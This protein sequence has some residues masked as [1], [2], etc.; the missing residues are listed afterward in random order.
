MD[1]LKKIFHTLFCSLFGIICIAVGIWNYTANINETN[2]NT[3]TVEATIS[4]IKEEYYIN[5]GHEKVYNYRVYVDYNYDNVEYENKEINLSSNL[6]KTGDVIKIKLNPE[7]PDNPIYIE[8]KTLSIIIIIIGILLV[9]F[10][11]KISTVFW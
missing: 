10:G 2:N 9:G 3:I 1:M 11:I 4:N 5:S 6:H 7:K 8:Q